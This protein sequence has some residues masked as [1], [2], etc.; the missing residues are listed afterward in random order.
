MTKVLLVEPIHESGVTILRQAGL[1]P[2]VSP[3]TDTDT[4]AELVRDDVFGIIVRTSL[5][6]GKVLEAGKD[7]K[8]IG[9][10]GIGYNNI[11]LAAADKRN[12]VIANVPDA[13]AYSVVEYVLTAIMM[14]SR[15]FL[16]GDKALRSGKLIQP[17]ASLPGLVKKFNLGG[18]ELPGRCVGVIGLGKIGSQV[19]EMA[20][21]F[22]RM[23][24]LAYDPY[25]KEAPPGARMVSDIREIYRSADFVTLHTPATQETENMID[26][27]VLDEMKTT[28]ILIN[29][30]RGELVDEQALAAALKQGKIAGAVLDVFWQEP[31]SITNPL[32]SA[33][34]VLLTP[35]IAGATDDAVERLAIGSARAVADYYQGKKPANIINPQVWERLTKRSQGE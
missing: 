31:P 29:A 21:S 2:V 5:L 26:A 30:G 19:A 3:S 8:I 10:H 12:I 22:L 14:V 20:A 7:L 25:K 18:S 33:P 16:D 27:A 4:L 9:R 28:A 24:V 13:N 32:F 1:E 15:K 35:H 17:G 11:D 23:D 34:N 6:A